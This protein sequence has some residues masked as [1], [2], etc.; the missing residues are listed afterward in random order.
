VDDL[1]AVPF[2]WS[3]QE[4]DSG[5]SQ[6][7][8]RIYRMVGADENKVTPVVGK[9]V[10]GMSHREAFEDL[11]KA[12]GWNLVDENK[13]KQ[14]RRLRKAARRPKRVNSKLP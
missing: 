12:M 13:T 1:G 8:E 7:S 9:V 2:S 5:L 14:E 10:F 4:L 6:G 3:S 11:A